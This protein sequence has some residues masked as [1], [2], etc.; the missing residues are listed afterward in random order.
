C[1]S[2]WLKATA[3]A[4]P[5]PATKQRWLREPCGSSTSARHSAKRPAWTRN[6]TRRETR[7]HHR[8]RRAA[9]P[10]TAPKALSGPG[11]NPGLAPAGIPADRSGE[12]RTDVHGIYVGLNHGP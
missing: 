6:T 9:A 2:G 8:R 11:A 4:A 5:P 10:R 3:G 7:H 1:S 12:G